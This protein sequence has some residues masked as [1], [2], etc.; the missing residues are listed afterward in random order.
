MNLM[1]TRCTIVILLCLGWQAGH[2]AAPWSMPA[3]WRIDE[4][5]VR[6]S[7]GGTQLSGTLFSP[8]GASDGPAVVLVQQNGTTTRDNPL[9]TQLAQAL[10]GIGFSVFAYDRR[11]HGES[12]GSSGRIAYDTL[13]HD[14]VAAKHALAGLDQVAAD[15]IGFWGISQG[16]WLALEAGVLSNPAFIITVSSPLTTPGR[17]MEFLAYNYVLTTHGKAAAVRALT[18]RRLV[19]RDY[20]RGDASYDEARAALEAVADEPWLRWA[21]LPDA[22]NLPEDPAESTWIDEMDFD[23]TEAFHATDAPLLFLLGG[24]DLDIPV[25]ET[26]TIIERG[27]PRENLEVV[28]LPGADHILRVVEE[29]IIG[30]EANLARPVSESVEYFTVL[31]RWLGDR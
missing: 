7:S 28:V 9:F 24:E 2:A 21:W 29:P 18:T 19:M 5:E 22:E 20:F 6:F 31:G 30:E 17:Q 26:L 4:I 14:A 13:A 3:S 8:V 16:G 15:R 11:G 10:T 12:E 25:A 27:E 23:P 1:F